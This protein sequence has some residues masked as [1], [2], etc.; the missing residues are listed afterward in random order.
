M[1]EKYQNKERKDV[2]P[3][4]VESERK[5]YCSICGKEVSIY[6]ADILEAS[7][8]PVICKECMNKVFKNEKK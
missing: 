3:E 7:G 5:A 2:I 6:D 8:Q 4:M 1:D